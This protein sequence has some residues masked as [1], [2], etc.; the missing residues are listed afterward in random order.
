MLKKSF[1]KAVLIC[2]LMIA[3]VHTAFAQKTADELKAEQ[4][5]LKTELKSKDVKKRHDKL[6]KMKDPGTVGVQ[7]VDE[8]AASSAKLLVATKEFNVTVPEM[9]KRT[10]GETVD[11]VT[12]VTVKKPTLDELTALA[13]EIALAVS[14]VADAQSV[15]QTAASDIKSLPP[16]KAPKAAKSLNFSKDALSLVLPELQLNA[17][18]VANLI[19]TLKTSGNL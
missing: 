14:G 3:T 1:F 13:T 5:Q 2:G 16:T 15:V 19:E 10:V 12:D 17:K 4:E 9:Y 11:G 6:A 18:V 8:L 7:S